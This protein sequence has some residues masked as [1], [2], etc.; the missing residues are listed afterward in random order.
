MEKLDAKISVK[1]VVNE[2]VEQCPEVRKIRGGTTFPEARRG[3]GLSSGGAREELYLVKKDFVLVC[4]V[5]VEE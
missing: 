4:E 2:H 5:F 3:E 1:V